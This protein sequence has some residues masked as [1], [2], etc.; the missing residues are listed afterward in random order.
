MSIWLIFQSFLSLMDKYLVK[1]VLG[2]KNRIYI[3]HMYKNH[4]QAFS[5]WFRNDHKNPLSL[6]Y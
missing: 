5:N 4:N 1:Y 2:Q 3:Y 6:H